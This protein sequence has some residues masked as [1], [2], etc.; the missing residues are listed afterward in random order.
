MIYSGLLCSA[1]TYVIFS[2]L[3]NEHD[4]TR[5]FTL[6]CLI[7]VFNAVASTQYLTAAYAVASHV[8]EDRRTQ[9]IG[10]MEMTTGIG[11]ILG[12]I[13]GSA[14]YNY[15]GF[16][17]PF[18]LM[19]GVFL[20]GL[21]LV[22]VVIRN[23]DCTRNTSVVNSL[24]LSH[25]VYGNSG[26]FSELTFRQFVKI[27]TSLSAWGTVLMTIICWSSMDFIMP[28]LQSHVSIANPD[29]SELEATYITGVMF[30]IYAVA[31]GVSTPL[32]FSDYAE[33]KS[34]QVFFFS[35]QI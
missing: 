21:P 20:L 9:A 19:A 18:R 5:F 14:L 27:F 25:G 12:P 17:L 33:K 28:I 13:A 16:G 29:R 30:V 6:S 35:F 31:Y 23:V 2:F 4:P 22:F 11:M 34:N 26:E 8:W 7:R 24:V 10:L 3:E 32:R 15:G 1:V